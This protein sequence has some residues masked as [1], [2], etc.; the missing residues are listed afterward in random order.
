MMPVMDICRMMFTALSSVAKV[1]V[2]EEKNTTS[3]TRVSSGASVR[4]LSAMARLGLKRGGICAHVHLAF[5]K[6]PSTGR[7][8]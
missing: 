3:A 8:W 1:V 2:V 7:I 5:L 6:L 4:S